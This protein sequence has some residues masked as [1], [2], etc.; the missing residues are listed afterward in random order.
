MSNAVVK[1]NGSQALPT[2]LG[3][4]QARIP[5]GGNSRRYQGPHEEGGGKPEGEG[6]LR[7]GVVSGQ[8]FEQIEKAIAE[9]PPNIKTPLVPKNVPWFTVRAQDF[10]N[11][12]SHSRSSTRLEKTV[13][14]A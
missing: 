11:P 12:K 2:V 5:A 9:A 8:S 13:A 14:T 10:P 6:N 4:R 3:Q 7:A 1:V